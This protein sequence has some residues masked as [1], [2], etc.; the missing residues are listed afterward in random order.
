MTG[1]KQVLPAN[2]PWIVLASDAEGNIYESEISVSAPWS[3]TLRGKNGGN[4]GLEP[5]FI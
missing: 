5:K 3:L 4:N 1:C 2:A